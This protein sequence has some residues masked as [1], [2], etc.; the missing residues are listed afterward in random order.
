MP[1][2]S[3]SPATGRVPPWVR[4]A[5]AGVAV[6]CSAHPVVAALCRAL[7]GPM[8]ST[9]A[10]PA[11]APPPRTLDAFDP[12]LRAAVDV[13]VGGDTGGLERPTPIRDARSG[14]VLRD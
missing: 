7:G 10:N 3:E 6:R 5:H 11:G 9:S 13:I 14:Q 2:R 4:G 1:A 8:V 12:H